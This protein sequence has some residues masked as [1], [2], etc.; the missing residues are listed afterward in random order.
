M[1]WQTRNFRMLEWQAIAYSH[2][3]RLWHLIRTGRYPW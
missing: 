1:T 2:G 3:W